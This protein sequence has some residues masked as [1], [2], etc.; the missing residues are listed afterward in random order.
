MCIEQHSQG[1]SIFLG[2]KKETLQKNKC[3][4]LL[5]STLAFKTGD[6]TVC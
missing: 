5:L 4:Y 3:T 1:R 6:R 2:G